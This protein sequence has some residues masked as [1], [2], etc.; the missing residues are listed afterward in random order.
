MHELTAFIKPYKGFYESLKDAIIITS[1][2]GSIVFVNKSAEEVFD[3]SAKKLIGKK[4]G[5]YFLRP[6]ETINKLFI[7]LGHKKKINL[8]VECRKGSRV[9]PLQL[10]G[11]TIL[12][13]H[14]TPHGIL[15]VFL[16]PFDAN[17]ALMEVLDHNSV[18]T[19][20]KHHTD[21][22][23]IISDVIRGNNI[24][25]SDSIR[26]L[27]GWEPDDFLSGGYPFVVSLTHPDDVAQ[28][29]QTYHDGMIKRA[30]E[31]RFDN[32]P[33]IYVYRKRH[34]DGSWRWIRSQSFVLKR[35]EQ[36]SVT[37]TVSFLRDITIEKIHGVSLEEEIRKNIIPQGLKTLWTVEGGHAQSEL[38]TTREKQILKMVRE[39]KSTKG[40]AETLGLT[41][42]SVN[43]FRKKIMEK[44]EAKN[45]AELIR[46]SYELKIF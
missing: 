43:S 20:L 3:L 10:C 12:N 33:I 15:L 16:N 35:N 34:R 39:G 37:N 1:L 32:E 6:E 24:F 4:C 17:E 8:I 13:Q 31:S 27:I 44:L 36:G 38:L 40:I 41:V 42:A 11:T 23:V 2:D 22:A 9:V 19:A 46:R 25:C 26:E 28:L 7:E 45:T 21:E 5:D 18:I 30:G 29:A 14:D